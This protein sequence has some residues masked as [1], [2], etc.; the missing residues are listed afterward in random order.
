MKRNQEEESS[1]SKHNSS[2]L[3]PNK[4]QKVRKR[5]INVATNLSFIR[6]TRPLRKT[7]VG[8]LLAESIFPAVAVLQVN[9]YNKKST[10]NNNTY[11]HVKKHHLQKMT[12][13]ISKSLFLIKWFILRAPCRGNLLGQSFVS[14]DRGRG[15]LQDEDHSGSHPHSFPGLYLMRSGRA[16]ESFRRGLVVA[17]L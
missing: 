10:L 6:E 5:F 7:F 3:K 17:D 15:P 16:P 2:L 11:E 4:D 9:R 1:L 8:Y 13:N 14:S 12:E